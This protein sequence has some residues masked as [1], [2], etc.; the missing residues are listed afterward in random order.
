MR[1]LVDSV[2]SPLINWLNNVIS[3][4]QHLSVP[5]SRPLDYSK[6]F[7]YFSMLGSYWMTLITTVCVLSFIYMITYIIVANIGLIRKF[8]DL[9][10]WW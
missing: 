6:Y 2:F 9:I 7:G 3:Y 8:K 5:L 1:N 4:L 10:Q